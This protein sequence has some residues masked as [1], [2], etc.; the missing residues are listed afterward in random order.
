[1]PVALEGSWL[2][3]FHHRINKAEWNEERTEGSVYSLLL[4]LFGGLSALY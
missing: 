3:V 4:L 2:T 1:M